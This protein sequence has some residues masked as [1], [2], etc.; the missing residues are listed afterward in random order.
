MI[1]NKIKWYKVVERKNNA[2]FFNLFCIGLFKSNWKKV[3]SFDLGIHAFSN[4]N[5]EVCFKEKE[6]Q[7][8]KRTATGLHESKGPS[9]FIKIFKQ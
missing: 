3:L 6:F 1:V 9:F 5:Q 7:K 8:A 4:F 2:T